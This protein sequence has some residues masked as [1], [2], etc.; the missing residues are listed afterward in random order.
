MIVS[1]AE[2]D[3]HRVSRAES[4]FQIAQDITQRL[5]PMRVQLTEAS[6]R[7]A[8]VESRDL[9][10]ILI[11]DWN[12]PPLE[13]GSSRDT[14][15]DPGDRVVVLT[16]QTGVQ[17]IM[18]GDVELSLQP[19]TMVMLSTRATAKLRLSMSRRMRKRTLTFPAVSLEACGSDRSVPE[20]MVLD[21]TRP[22]VKLFRD[23]VDAIW[24]RLQEMNASEI[25]ATRSSL[26]HLIAGAIRPEQS[27]VADQAWLPALR[28]QLEQWIIDNLALGR[29]LV[30]EIAHANNVS[31]R[32]VH[33]AFSLTGDT[34]GSVI[35]AHRLSNARRD[36]VTTHLPVGAIAHKWGYYDASH[37]GRD[38]RR[39]FSVSPGGYRD[40]F[41]M[42][43]EANEQP[44][45]GSL[46]KV[47]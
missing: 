39:S 23:Y 36:L 37:F 25:E 6:P 30:E 38:F 19:G 24:P 14:E 4:E 7:P 22:L 46:Q 40:E 26:L 45:L 47:G 9:G 20:S 33:R 41:G 28:L 32:T 27:S 1:P 2:H 18:L 15:F 13:A 11:T 8:C 29:V 5:I 31:T 35:R 42:S 17:R 3:F 10:D 34:V 21:E 44:D 43:Q 16:A 12:C